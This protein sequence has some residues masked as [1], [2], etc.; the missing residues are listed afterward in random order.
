MF[1]RNLTLKICPYKVHREDKRGQNLSYKR[2]FFYFLH[3]NSFIIFKLLSFWKNL[4]FKIQGLFLSTDNLDLEFSW[5]ALSNCTYKFH[6]NQNPITCALFLKI[7]N[8]IFRDKSEHQLFNSLQKVIGKIYISME[9]FFW[10]KW[11]NCNMI[12]FLIIT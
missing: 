11:K 4:Y 5:H 8:F 7:W 10:K 6:E 1:S 9:I 2:I 12:F 3:A